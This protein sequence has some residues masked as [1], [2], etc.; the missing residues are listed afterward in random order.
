MVPTVIV[1]FGGYL[2]AKGITHW[3]MGKKAGPLVIFS[4]LMTLAIFDKQQDKEHQFYSQY[5]TGV[6]YENSRG[7]YMIIDLKISSEKFTKNHSG[8][9]PL[10]IRNGCNTNGVTWR[11]ANQIFERCNVLADSFKLAFNGVVPKEKY[12]ESYLDVGTLRHRLIKPAVYEFMRN[13]ATLIAN[14]IKGD[15]VVDALAR[16]IGAFTGQQVVAAAYA[17]FG[18]RDSFRAHWDTLDVFAVQ[19]LGRKRWLV[20]QPTFECPLHT[21]QSKDYEH[22][23]PKPEDVH[24]DFVLEPGDVFYLPRGWW[25]NPLPLGEATFHLAF[26]TFPPFA[27]EYLSWAVDES[28]HFLSARKALGTWDQSQET[29]HSLAGYF[30]EFITDPENYRRFQDKFYSSL[31]L[32][33]SLAIDILGN[34]ATHAVSDDQ[35]LRVAMNNLHGLNEAYIIANGAKVTLDSIGIL[36]MQR[37]ARSPGTQ[38]S[39]LLKEYPDSD[40]N[41]I[42]ALITELCRQ[43]ILEPWI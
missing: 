41:K 25:H 6:Q 42:R 8:R 3:E 7:E 33:S 15:S 24:M 43:D 17:A 26:G 20:Y 10:L 39:E 37:I 22:A 27:I 38:V 23:Y 30:S 31:R 19:L 21:Q 28:Q 5:R 4:L 9:Q 29:I 34:P 16:Q 36:L 2:V 14:Q 18:N 40:Q 12:V 11:Q 32:D 13:G 1:I 35:K